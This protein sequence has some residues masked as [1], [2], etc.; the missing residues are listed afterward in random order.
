MVII[1]AVEI[2]ADG[3][4]NAYS[5]AEI[6]PGGLFGEMG[7]IDDAPRSTTAV[8]KIDTTCAAVIRTS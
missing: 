5:L 6:G 8:A 2:S 7:L 4:G 3:D 1:G